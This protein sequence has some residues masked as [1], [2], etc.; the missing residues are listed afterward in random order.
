MP[1]IPIGPLD[2]EGDCAAAIES[3]TA[4]AAWPNDPKRRKEYVLLQTVIFGDLLLEARENLILEA[5]ERGD[6]PIAPSI[7]KTNEYREKWIARQIGGIP[8]NLN[9]QLASAPALS[10][11]C[12]EL[13]K[14]RKEWETPAAIIGVMAAIQA[15]HK[16][17]FRFGPS[18]NRAKYLLEEW[19]KGQPRDK[20]RYPAN[21]QSVNDRWVKFRS[22]AHLCAGFSKTGEEPFYSYEEYLA[23]LLAAAKSYQDFGTQFKSH[24]QEEFL[25]NDDAWLIPDD[26]PLALNV[27]LESAPL[28]ERE[29]EILRNYQRA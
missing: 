1:I 19:A 4:I 17:E 27:S 10:T 18:V 29:L 15:H 2:N 16:E 6:T 5:T 14:I 12:E 22:V 23:A 28:P 9:T 25:L 20:R 21:Q 26:C 24:G 3:I 8:D 13:K 11:L 7:D